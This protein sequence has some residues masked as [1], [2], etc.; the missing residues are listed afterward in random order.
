MDIYKAVRALN[1]MAYATS[2]GKLWMRVAAL[3]LCKKYGASDEQIGTAVSHG[4][5]V[6]DGIDYPNWKD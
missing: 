1:I 2:K 4:W 6:R 3:R 5:N